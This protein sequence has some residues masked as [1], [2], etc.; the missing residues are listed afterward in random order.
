MHALII[1][2]EPLIAAT[3]EAELQDLGYTSTSVVSSEAD[4]LASAARQQPDF[5]TVD[6][7]LAG[8]SGTHAALKICAE[9]AI[10]LVIITGYPFEIAL[11]DVV[12][13]GKP[14]SSAAF[15]AAWERAQATARTF[16]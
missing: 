13:L 11:P 9:K 5:I 6:H 15:R 7:K 8:G 1:E 12:T 16:S 2:D 14:F 4:A 10:P 3:I